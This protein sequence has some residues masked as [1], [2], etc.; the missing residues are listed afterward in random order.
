[1]LDD[2]KNS[3][4][5]CSGSRVF[6][7]PRYSH[8]YPRGV[9]LFRQ[10]GDATDA[11]YLESGILKLVRSEES[12]REI[13]L[14]LRFSGSLVG[15]AAVI[16][17]KPHPY[18]AVTAMPCNITRVSSSQFRSDIVRDVSLSS[19]ISE[20]LSGEI[21]QLIA[22]VSHLT[23]VP[24]RQ[25]LEQFLWELCEQPFANH[26]SPARATFKLQLP[27]KHYEIADLLSITPTYLCRLLNELELRSVISR[28]KGWIVVNRPSEL[29]HADA[30]Y[31]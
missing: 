2:L 7:G 15:S 1:M 27:L 22:R 8:G 24:A 20:M 12:G 29:W 19:R 14:D 11:Y 31:Q 3:R 26:Q 28:T 17:R 10:G 18:S 6:V 21:L 23:C 13:L 9:E 5:D 30:L 4:N 25:R 16:M